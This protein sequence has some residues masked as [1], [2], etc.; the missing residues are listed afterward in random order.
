MRVCVLR[1]LTRMLTDA[2]G[3]NSFTTLIATV[4]PIK[5]NAGETLSTLLFATRC[6]DVATRA[7]LNAEVDYKELCERL[8]LALTAAQEVRRSPVCRRCCCCCP[9]G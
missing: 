7:T 6:M 9:C 4:G 2:L 8:R 1:Q 3:G 5:Y